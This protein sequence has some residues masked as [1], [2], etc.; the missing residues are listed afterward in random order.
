MRFNA[1]LVVAGV[2]PKCFQVATEE[3]QARSL[4]RCP[5][6]PSADGAASPLSTAA[7]KNPPCT[8]R[9][10]RSD[11]LPHELRSP[12][13]HSKAVVQTL[14]QAIKNSRPKWTAV[15]HWLRGQDLNLRPPGYEPDEL[16]SALP[17]DIQAPCVGVLDYNSTTQGACQAF[18]A[19][20]FMVL[21]VFSF[22]TVQTCRYTAGN[23]RP[24]WPAAPR[25][26][27]VPQ[28]GR[29]PAQ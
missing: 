16:P 3:G 24:C 17:R 10:R 2:V 25:G 23:T 12:V 8:R 26:Y 4:L 15:F 27:R 20:N 18:K 22:R 5:A 28:Y 13:S 6:R 9:W 14:P 1:L 7:P 21:P 29:A 11:F 19:K